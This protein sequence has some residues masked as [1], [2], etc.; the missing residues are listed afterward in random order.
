[1][2]EFAWPA[3]LVTVGFILLIAGG[4]LLVRG[5]ARLAVQWGIPPLVVGLT[6]VAFATSAPELVVSLQAVYSGSGS[7]A[8]GNLVGSNIANV[9]LVL[10]LSA[11]AAP[12]M[13]SI[14]VIQVDVPLVIAA[15]VLM[16]LL[17]LDGEI[18][19]GNGLIMAGL[20]AGY[21]WWS[22]R[23]ESQEAAGGPENDDAENPEPTGSM[24]M[25]GL[26]V[27]A[28][29]LL[30]VLGGDWLVQGAVRI[31]G[32]LGV[33]ELVIGLTVIAVGTSLP[34][35]VTSIIAVLRNAREM[36][37]GNVLGSNLFNILGVLGVSAMLAPAGVPVPASAL[38]LD[39]PVM[40][41]TALACLP[42]FFTGHRIARWEGGLFFSYYLAYLTYLVLNA[43][44]HQAEAD[45]ARVM[46]LFV[47]PL[48]VL[49][50]SI[51]AFR[52]WRAKQ[53]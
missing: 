51:V 53:A 44:H 3:V 9:L 47:M 20:L 11:L 17:G 19:A 52:A 27:L 8:L 18:D 37:V 46:T 15:S 39:I 22:L 16:L 28:G 12:L 32:L 30:L 29:I 6:V 25:N 42:I 13:V 33:D 10:G 2:Q 49:T 23:E 36:A 31:A 40:I 41:A 14:R 48:T 45:F 21:L 5:A 4:E 1:M 50:L 7:L 34:E 24:A 38:A 26:L 35:L 43:T